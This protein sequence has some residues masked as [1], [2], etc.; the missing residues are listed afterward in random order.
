MKEKTT[1]KRA[2]LSQEVNL[3]GRGKK[4]TTIFGE[5]ILE[6]GGVSLPP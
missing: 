6:K 1:E 4:E 5:R 3:K 2:T